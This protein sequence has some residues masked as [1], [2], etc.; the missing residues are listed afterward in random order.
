[1][2][3]LQGQ[4]KK[5]ADKINEIDMKLEQLEEKK[6]ENENKVDLGV[7]SI[8]DGAVR[9]DLLLPEEM[10]D[11]EKK[12]RLTK[13]AEDLQLLLVDIEKENK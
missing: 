8:I 2:M 6:K 7:L 11:E 13:I 4:I 5:I 10:F 3:D 1:M 12:Q 9:I